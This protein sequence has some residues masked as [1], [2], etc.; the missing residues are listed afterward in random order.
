MRLILVAISCALEGFGAQDGRC[1]RLSASHF[2]DRRG[3]AHAR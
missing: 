3:D 1:R 2:D